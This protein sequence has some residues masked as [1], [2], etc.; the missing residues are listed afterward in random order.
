VVTEGGRSKGLGILI[1][2]YAR[3][4]DFENVPFLLKED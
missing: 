1:P 2:R 3:A 4:N